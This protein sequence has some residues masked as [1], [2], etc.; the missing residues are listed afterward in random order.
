MAPSEAP[1]QLIASAF[2][3]VAQATGVAVFGIDLS[4]AVVDR[5][6]AMNRCAGTP[7]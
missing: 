6:F 2:V 1:I 4:W 3:K 5:R 7:P